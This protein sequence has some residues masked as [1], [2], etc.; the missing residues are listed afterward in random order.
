MLAHC[1]CG[2]SRLALQQVSNPLVPLQHGFAQQRTPVVLVVV[3]TQQT[4]K[5]AAS[6]TSLV[7]SLGRRQI[8]AG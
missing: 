1:C 5:N 6:G 8:R 7:R 2:Y 4:H 3:E